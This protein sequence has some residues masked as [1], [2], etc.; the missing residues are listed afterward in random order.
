MDLIERRR[1]STRRNTGGG[2]HDQNRLYRGKF[3]FNK[4]ENIKKIEYCLAELH[5]CTLVFS[6]YINIINI[7]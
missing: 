3:I 5:K 4:G 7:Y 6:K 1:G 2:N